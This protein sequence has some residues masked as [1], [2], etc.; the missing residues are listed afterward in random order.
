MWLYTDDG[1]YS[2]V[3]KPGDQELT[4]RARVKSDL[5]RLKARYLPGLSDITETKDGDYRFRAKVSHAAFAHGLYSIGLDINYSNFKNTVAKKQGI[6]RA[7][8]Y[9]NIWAD[10][11]ALGDLKDNVGGKKHDDVDRPTLSTGQRLMMRALYHIHTYE[12]LRTWRC[13]PFFAVAEKLGLTRRAKNQHDTAP[14]TY[15]KALLH[16]GYQKGWIH[17]PLSDDEWHEVLTVFVYKFLQDWTTFQNG[18]PWI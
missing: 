11:I 3:H 9:G 18:E 2:V 6:D 17:E 1:F 10:S 7:K 12:A 4:V 5:E 15:A 16:D 14:E 8:I 13:M